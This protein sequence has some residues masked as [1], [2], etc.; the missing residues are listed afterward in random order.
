VDLKGTF[1][2][3]K[4]L[5]IKDISG[6]RYGNSNIPRIKG[7]YS[8]LKNGLSASAYLFPPRQ[9]KEFDVINCHNFPSYLAALSPKVKGKPIVWHCNE[10]PLELYPVPLQG[11]RYGALSFLKIVRPLE[12]TA[13]SKIR[14]ITVHGRNIEE[15]VRRIYSKDPLVVGP[16]GVNTR[17]FRPLSGKTVRDKYGLGDAPCVM[18]LAAFYKRLDLVL[19]IFSEIKK[20]VKD[21]RLLLAGA[22]HG[23]SLEVQNIIER[24]RLEQSVI[25]A[26]DLD[27]DDLPCYYAAADVFVFPQPHWGFS[28]VVMEAMACGKPVIV[29]DTCAAAEIING[30]NG[31]TTDITNPIH[32][33]NT[34]TEILQDEG[35]REQMGRIARQFAVRFLDDRI[36]LEKYYKLLHAVKQR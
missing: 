4:N 6:F 2:E 18:T 21:A 31:V 34:I 15:R 7:A 25:L 22:S 28:L 10:P 11:V 17:K 24:F 29:P 1:E 3:I 5:T 13:V 32:T 26:P 14:W 35:R 36:F 20:K 33:A 12:K 30:S 9:I 8:F 16:F 27:E 19:N 23:R